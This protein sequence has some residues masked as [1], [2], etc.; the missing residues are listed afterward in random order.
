MHIIILSETQYRNY[1]AVHS[2]RNYKQ[3]VEYANMMKNYGYDKMFL[4]LVDNSN[5][6]IASTPEFATFK[7]NKNFTKTCF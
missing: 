1:S 4:G 2:K 7:F 5:N 3:T 6:V